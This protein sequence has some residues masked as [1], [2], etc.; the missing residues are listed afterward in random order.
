MEVAQRLGE[1]FGRRVAHVRPHE[2]RVG[3]LEQF[4]QRGHR[5]ERLLVDAVGLELRA[6]VLD[7]ALGQRHVVL[8]LAV[9]L[10]V[11]VDVHAVQ[12]G[13]ELLDVLQHLDD[14]RVLLLGDLARHEDAEVAD[15]LVEEADDRLAVGLDLLRRRLYTSAIQ[16]NACCGGVML[17]PIDAKMMMGCLIDLRS[18]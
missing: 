11:L 7:P 4:G 10:H 5:L 17:S 2:Q 18:K 14:L 1:P 16:L 3:T 9:R 15:V 6:Q 13:R 8:D 12:T